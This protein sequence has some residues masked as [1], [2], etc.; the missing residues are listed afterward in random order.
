[1]M[2]RAPRRL[3]GG[4]TADAVYSGGPGSGTAPAGSEV[5]PVAAEDGA[6]DD[7]RSGPTVSFSSGIGRQLQT[8][9]EVWAWAAQKLDAGD[10]A[11]P[12][13]GDSTQWPMTPRA[14]ASSVR[15][16]RGNSCLGDT[17]R[18]AVHALGWYRDADG[19]GFGDPATICPP[20][21]RQRATL[22]KDRLRRHRLDRLSRRPEE[23]DANVM[24]GRSGMGRSMR[25][26]TASSSRTCRP[27]PGP[28]RGTPQGMK[29]RAE[30]PFASRRTA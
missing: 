22:R 15:R 4:Q 6:C 24:S 17:W 5:V 12:P 19:D 1:M 2:P 11:V 28:S 7:P 29:S 13:E 26:T 20:V 18:T 30:S 25:S 16:I 3:F 27:S 14:T 23:S 9:P 10:R 8:F 21:M